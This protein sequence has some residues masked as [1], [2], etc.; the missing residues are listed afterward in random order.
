MRSWIEE[1]DSSLSV[2]LPL[3]IQ[4]SVV[5]SW[6]VVDLLC[7]WWIAPTSGADTSKA[8]KN[9]IIPFFILF[10]P[11]S[12][13]GN[14]SI[15]YPRTYLVVYDKEKYKTYR[16][17]EEFFLKQRKVWCDRICSQHGGGHHREN[18]SLETLLFSLIWFDGFFHSFTPRLF[19]MIQVC[20]FIFK[21]KYFIV[22]SSN[23]HH[24]FR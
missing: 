24:F 6:N 12:P 15:R 2:S 4:R 19:L 23:L 1:T 5:V 3:T 20:K 9:S 13:V 22:Q 17:V 21:Y 7:G 11:P 14:K 8:T 10:S 16:D 18:N